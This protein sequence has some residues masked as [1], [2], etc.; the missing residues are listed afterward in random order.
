MPQHVSRTFLRSLN[1]ASK[2]DRSTPLEM[3]IGQVSYFKKIESSKIFFDFTSSFCPLYP[4][5]Y[6]SSSDIES[7]ESTFPKFTP[8]T[9]LSG[10][11]PSH[12]RGYLPII[13]L[14]QQSNLHHIWQAPSSSSYYAPFYS[15]S[16]SSTKSTALT[17]TSFPTSSASVP[18]VETIASP[19]QLAPPPSLSMAI[20]ST[21]Q[22]L[23]VLSMPWI[24]KRRFNVIREVE[25]DK[26]KPVLPYNLISRLHWKTS[27]EKSL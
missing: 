21:Q 1:A 23:V 3:D 17:W 14:P 16:P 10:F 4:H 26:E 22:S 15:C 20:K 25:G 24:V 12:R 9:S 11:L 7:S 18:A 27:I 13:R 6:I 2:P 8:F 19:L 5:S